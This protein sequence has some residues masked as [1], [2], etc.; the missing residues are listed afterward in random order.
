MALSGIPPTSGFISKLLIFRSSAIAA[1]N[2]VLGLLVVGGVIT[3]IYTSRA[4]QRIW[5]HTPTSDKPI[6]AKGDRLWAPG[7]LIGLV[8]VMGLWAE[9]LV[10][11]AQ[12]TAVWLGDPAV[13]IDA[14]LGT[15]VIGP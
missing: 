3:L 2:L 15:A 5:W 8:L 9:P 13:Y 6:K 10:G 4:F 12:E 7:L 14:V 1:E 11:L